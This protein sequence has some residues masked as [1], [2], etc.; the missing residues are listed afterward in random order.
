M[1]TCQTVLASTCNSLQPCLPAS[2]CL[3]LHV[4]HYSHAYLLECACVYMQLTTAMPTCQSVLASTCNSLQPCLPA[5]LCLRLHATHYGSRCTGV[6][7]VSD[8]CKKGT[9]CNTAH[10]TY[11][12]S[13]HMLDTNNMAWRYHAVKS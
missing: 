8:V 3:R 9:E 10:G 2:V 4:T 13:V 1:P 6:M 7:T 5:R 11:Q 12:P